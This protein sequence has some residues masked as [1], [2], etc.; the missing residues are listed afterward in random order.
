MCRRAVAAELPHL[1]PSAS[2]KKQCT[3]SPSLKQELSLINGTIHVIIP[4]FY[5]VFYWDT[6]TSHSSR[7]LLPL[8]GEK[9]NF[10]SSSNM[11]MKKN[12]TDMRENKMKSVR[13][14]QRKAML[15][16]V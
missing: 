3:R 16:N 5:L 1:E 7:S 4:I 8:G 9:R 15:I 10:F 12:A 13:Q 2:T 14:T 6:H 11:V